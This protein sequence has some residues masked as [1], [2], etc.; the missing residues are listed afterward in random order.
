MAYF[1]PRGEF[2][3]CN[4][5]QLSATLESGIASQTMTVDLAQTTFID[6]STLRVFEHVADCR[7]ELN[8]TPLR[9]VNVNDH[10]RR[11]FSI[12]GLDKTFE[13]EEQRFYSRL[14]RLK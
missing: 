10:F 4:K 2:D 8:A 7:R 9:I 12:C 11:I 3:F 6:A 13:I 5:S 1:S 14:K